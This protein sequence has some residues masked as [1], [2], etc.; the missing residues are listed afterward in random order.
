MLNLDALLGEIV[1]PRTKGFPLGA[2]PIPLSAVGA[3]GWN[4]LRGDLPFPVALLRE[5]ALDHNHAWMRDFTAATGALLAPHGK[6]T[7]A[8]QIFAEQ[9]AA[10]A[11]GITVAN[12][13]QLGVCVHFGIRRVIMANQLLGDREIAEVIRLSRAASGPRVPFSGRLPPATGA[14]RSRSRQA[15]ADASASRAARD[16]RR[17]RAHGL[18][19]LR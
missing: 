1:D 11:W 8:P 16:R 18:P 12:V 2:A 9:L 4:L 15:R 17:G 10:G 13:Q 7:M 3:Q 5:S 19:Q 6:T 14:D